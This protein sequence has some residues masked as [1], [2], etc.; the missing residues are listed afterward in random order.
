MK[1]AYTKPD[2]MFEDFSLSESIASG[3]E[4][5]LDTQARGNCGYAYEGGFGSTLFIDDSTGCDVPTMDDKNNGFCYHD[6]LSSII[7]FNS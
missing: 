4:I 6:P 1:K 5:I 3:C 7:L 2:I